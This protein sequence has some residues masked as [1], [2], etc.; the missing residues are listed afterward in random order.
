VTC[1]SGLTGH[2][3]WGRVTGATSALRVYRSFADDGVDLPP[4]ALV[5][6]TLVIP[7]SPPPP[8]AGP[9][10]H[11]AAEAAR[12]AA[13]AL[14]SEASLYPAAPLP[15]AEIPFQRVLAETG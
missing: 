12:S 4:Y 10:S 14:A 7:K 13:E 6:F 2:T 15:G 3:T 11:A 9:A 1:P 8:A 5:A